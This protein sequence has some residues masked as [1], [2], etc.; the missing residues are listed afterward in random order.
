MLRKVGF[1]AFDFW[2]LEG[3]GASKKHFQLDKQTKDV[4][5]DSN[6]LIHCMDF[7]HQTSLKCTSTLGVAASSE[8]TTR[9]AMDP[10]EPSPAPS[11][12]FSIL[13]TEESKNIAVVHKTNQGGNHCGDESTCGVNLWS[14][15]VLN[16]VCSLFLRISW[17]SHGKQHTYNK[18][19]TEC[20]DFCCH[21]AT[22]EKI[23]GN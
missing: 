8:S 13:D 20:P 6:L 18:S 2:D 4:R 1:N 9:W 23:Y 14:I 12:N 15:C 22:R 3:T 7:A 21:Q 17:F 11:M 5:S 16:W 19:C 10:W